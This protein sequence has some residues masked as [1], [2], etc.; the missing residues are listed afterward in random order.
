MR[1]ALVAMLRWKIEEAQLQSAGR[2]QMPCKR[3]AVRVEQGKSLTSAVHAATNQST[4]W[5]VPTWTG[6]HMSL[7][8]GQDFFQDQQRC[9]CK[10]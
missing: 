6:A 7:A 4:C 1:N 2:N 5:P 10:Q 3:W 8:P 9:A